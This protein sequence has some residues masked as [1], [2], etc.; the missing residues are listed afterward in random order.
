MFKDL[1][2]RKFY[3]YTCLSLIGNILG[4]IADQKWTSGEGQRGLHP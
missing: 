3:S 2:R 4:E 1:W